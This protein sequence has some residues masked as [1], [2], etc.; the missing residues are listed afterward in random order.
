LGAPDAE[1]C[2]AG[3]EEL[4][5][6]FAGC[7]GAGDAHP[8]TKA[9]SIASPAKGDFERVASIYTPLVSSSPK[10]CIAPTV[11]SRSVRP[12]PQLLPFQGRSAGPAP[13]PR[14]GE[15]WGEGQWVM[16]MGHDTGLSFAASWTKISSDSGLAMASGL[17][18]R[19][20]GAPARMR[21]TGI[22]SFLPLIVRGTWA[23]S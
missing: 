20:G 12:L 22:S 21:L 5:P 10:H 23:I 18:T 14:W 4:L 11:Q 7:D 9:S 8:T 19:S 6:V 17:M 16:V 2:P 15:G 3:A 1:G 13:S